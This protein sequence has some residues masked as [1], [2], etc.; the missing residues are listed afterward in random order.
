[1]TALQAL[2]RFIATTG[3]EDARGWTYTSNLNGVTA[4]LTATRAFTVTVA[5]VHI[6]RNPTTAS[7][8]HAKYWCKL[9]NLECTPHPYDPESNDGSAW[10]PS[11]EGTG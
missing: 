9:L 4:N 10:I 6:K 2:R 5:Y 1:M 8:S 7:E 3:K 11:A